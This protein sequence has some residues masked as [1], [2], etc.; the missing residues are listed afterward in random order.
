M[1]TIAIA[2]LTLFAVSAA[3]AQDGVVSGDTKNGE[4]H[5]LADGC[6]QCH[7]VGGYGAALTGP[8]LRRTSLPY[9]SFAHQLRAPS[10]AMPPY[11]EALVSDRT[12]RDIYAYL[13]GLSDS[14]DPKGL[15]LLMKMGVK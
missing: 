9:E 5:Y 12:V 8:K 3:V 4:R 15:P 13:E 7:G 2:L 10:S 11:E 1:R 6:Y 14:P